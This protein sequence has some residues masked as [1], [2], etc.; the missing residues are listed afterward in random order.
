MWPSRAWSPARS[1]PGRPRAARPPRDRRCPGT[2]P[3]R[4]ARRPTAAATG[5]GRVTELESVA[6]DADHDLVPLGPPPPEERL[7]LRRHG[8]GRLPRV[9]LRWICLRR[10]DRELAEQLLDLDAG[11]RVHEHDG[12]GSLL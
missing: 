12:A 10:L 6:A 7:E 5:R 9:G 4:R 1:R 11:A 3:R 8:V 2:D